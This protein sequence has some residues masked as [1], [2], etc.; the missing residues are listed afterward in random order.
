MYEM[1]KGVTTEAHLTKGLR[2]PR[3]HVRPL[4][5]VRQQMVMNRAQRRRQ[6][7]AQIAFVHFS[8]ARTTRVPVH[9]VHHAAQLLV[10]VQLLAAVIGHQMGAQIDAPMK[11][12]PARQL[13]ALPLAQRRINVVLWLRLGLHQRPCVRQPRFQRL[14]VRPLEVLA[15]LQ[16]TRKW[17]VALVAPRVRVGVVLGTVALLPVTRAQQN[18]ADAARQVR[19]LAYVDAHVDAHQP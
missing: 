18:I 15:A 19:D 9:H 7:R 3:A 10:V 4:F 13:V 1:H 14:H 17:H 16:H 2:T 5:T 12:L 11:R 8:L 6:Q